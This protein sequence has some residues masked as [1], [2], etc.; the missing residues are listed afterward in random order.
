MTSTPPAGADIEIIDRNPS[1]TP[2]VLVPSAVRI[3]IA[4]EG[5]LA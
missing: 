2:D 4:A 1:G 5:D 3:T